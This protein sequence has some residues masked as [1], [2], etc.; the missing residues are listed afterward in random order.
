MSLLIYS[1]R[2][3]I[4]LVTA[5]TTFFVLLF[6]LL[7]LREP[8]V[9]QRVLQKNW[10]LEKNDGRQPIFSLVPWR[11]L[12]RESFGKIPLILIHGTL[13]ES[14]KFSNWS[15]LL[16]Q[17]EIDSSQAKKILEQY[18]IFVFRYPSNTSKP[19]EL[20]QKLIQALRELEALYK[21]E[22]Q[23]EP[24]QKR[25][26]EYKLIVSS[27]GG[28][29]L[30]RA[31]SLAPT[32]AE[33]IRQIIS[34]GT[35]FWGIPL[36]NRELKKESVAIAD[37]LLLRLVN[38]FY[39]ALPE[40]LTWKSTFPLGKKQELLAYQTHGCFPVRKKIIAYGAFL[41]S[42]NLLGFDLKFD[43]KFDFRHAWNALIHQ[44]FAQNLQEDFFHYYF[45]TLNDGLVPV[46]SSLFLAPSDRYLKILRKEI[47]KKGQEPSIT[48]ISKLLQK[49]N[50]VRLFSNLDHTD[51]T[52]RKKLAEFILQ[53]L[54]E[55]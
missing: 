48:K 49:K 7:V 9:A 46:Y 38:S 6:S 35:P 25:A 28:N 20:A 8:V 15:F 1:I 55:F 36:F 34:L 47:L 5:L 19:Q 21:Q 42:N 32:E 3:S 27:L 17:L 24:N 14:K 41:D 43:L 4:R 50:R 18:Q 39:P 10:S 26:F 16:N 2:Y 54:E 30:C 40:F 12:E 13:S 37:L 11:A 51:L 52:E 44:K 33:K 53:D 31:L 23:K 45:I 22:R 29:I